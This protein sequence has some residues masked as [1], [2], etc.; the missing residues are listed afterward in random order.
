MIV[1]RVARRFAVALASAFLV[2][3][4]D[5]A[6]QDALTRAK[7]LYAS[8][9]YDDALAVLDQLKLDSSSPDVV[10]AGQYRAFCLLALGRS[11]EGRK[12]I[13]GIVEADPLFQP[14]ET[15]MSPRLVTVFRDVRKQLLPRIVQQSYAEAKVAFDRKELEAA[16]IGYDRVLL[17]LNDPDLPASS[18]TT[19]LR[20]LASGFRDLSRVAPPP[21]PPK[22]A[23]P[24]P[25][26][27]RPS[28]KPADAP[29][30][31]RT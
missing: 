6:D 31:P 23:A 17:L 4:S 8:A 14:A 7:D 5:V 12:A 2:A 22:A 21:P 18:G 29:G 26:S 10:E 9:A 11:G 20:M 19:D 24:P 25:P 27:I 13:A 28:G 3:A 15:Q 1:N 16:A 30:P